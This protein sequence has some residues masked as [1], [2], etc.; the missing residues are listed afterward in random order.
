MRLINRFVLPALTALTLFAMPQMARADYLYTFDGHDFG[1]P[2]HF[3]FTQPQI[4]LTDFTVPAASLLNLSGDN[5]AS[6][7]AVTF[8]DPATAVPD[9]LFYYTFSQFPGQDFGWFEAFDHVGSY[10]NGACEDPATTLTIT[11]TAPEPAS[12]TLIGLGF[13]AVAWKRKVT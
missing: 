4:L 3:E 5:A 1:H 12:F 13:I 6:L 7:T 2:L 9:I 8:M 11:S 10:C